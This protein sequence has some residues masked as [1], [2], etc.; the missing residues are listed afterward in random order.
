MFQRKLKW[1]LAPVLCL[2]LFGSSVSAN[3][4]MVSELPGGGT[5]VHK[6]CESGD[7]KKCYL[8]ECTTDGCSMLV[9]ECKTSSWYE[10]DNCK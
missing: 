7:S 3:N 2:G 10:S 5:C 4:E 8:R 9:N 6:V 1:I